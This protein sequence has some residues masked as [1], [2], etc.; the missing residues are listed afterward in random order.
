[1]SNNRE[2]FEA[3]IMDYLSGYAD[4]HVDLYGEY[5]DPIVMRYWREWQ[6]NDGD[7]SHEN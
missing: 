2:E 1:M 5:D 7:I 6:E 4:L 3:W